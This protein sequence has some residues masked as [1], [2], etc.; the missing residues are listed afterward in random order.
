[1]NW[2]HLPLLSLVALAATG[3]TT[4]RDVTIEGAIRITILDVHKKVIH[5]PG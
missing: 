4:D 2:R 3:C 5:Y 1:M